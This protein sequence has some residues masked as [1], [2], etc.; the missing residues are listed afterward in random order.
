MEHNPVKAISQERQKSDA[1]ADV[2]SFLELFI[3]KREKQITEIELLVSR[4]EKKRHTE[5][6]AGQSFTGL[7]KFFSAKK[8]DHHLAVEY[9]HYVKKPMEQVRLLRAEI[10]MA[11]EMMAQSSQAEILAIF[12]AADRA[13]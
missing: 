3:A 13:V 8:P 12:A 9:I 11:R 7:R 10:E 2:H 6:R 4:Y 1:G 5:E